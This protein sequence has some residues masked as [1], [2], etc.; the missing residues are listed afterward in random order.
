MGI[1]A[2]YITDANKNPIKVAGNHKSNEATILAQITPL[3]KRY[4]VETYKSSDGNTWY[5]IYND[6]WKEC[7]GTIT[8]VPYDT[9]F[10]LNLPVTFS[11]TKYTCLLVAMGGGR[12]STQYTNGNAVQQRNTSSVI[13]RTDDY[14]YGRMWRAEGY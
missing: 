4:V 5:T 6:G 12:N 3:K 2:H 13:I 7:G 10:T 8:S 14:D 9:S 11:D 1:M